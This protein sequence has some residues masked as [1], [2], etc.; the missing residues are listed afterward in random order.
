MFLFVSVTCVLPLAD[1][2]GVFGVFMFF[3]GLC[4]GALDNGMFLLA[5]AYTRLS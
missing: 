1:H 2:V 3:H 4:L 5:L